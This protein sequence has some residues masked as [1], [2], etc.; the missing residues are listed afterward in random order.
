[1]KKVYI[2]QVPHK[3]DEETRAFV[4]AFNIAPA[5]EHGE[6][7]VMMP[8]RAPFHATAELVAQLRL[9]LKNYDFGAGDSLIAMGDPAI[10][11]AAAAL[12]GSMGG[13]FRLL[14]WDRNVG[15]YLPS[16]ININEARRT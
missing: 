8:H 10:I 12:L 3:R 1:M 16:I 11:A 13:R 2:T 5:E 9:H 7:V 15:R 4:P 14:K 6:L